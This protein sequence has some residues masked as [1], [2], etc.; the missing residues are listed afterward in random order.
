MKN[1]IA[2]GSLILV[3]IACSKRNI[4]T[5]V[6]PENI[7]LEYD[8]TAID[9]FSAGATSVDI[10]RNIRISSERYQDS[11]K[12]ALKLKQEEEK[13]QKELEKENKRKEEEE[14]KIKEKEKDME[15]ATPT[16]KESPSVI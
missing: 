15:K 5:E 9:S 13:I 16:P 12:A 1:T 14:R 11:V 7:Q 2:L 4:E 8:T 10:M 6:L 3:I